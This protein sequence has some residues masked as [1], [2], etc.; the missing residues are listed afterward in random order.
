MEAD[1]AEMC[2]EQKG[3]VGNAKDWEASAVVLKRKFMC[4]VHCRGCVC[5]YFTQK[6]GERALHPGLHEDGCSAVI[7]PLREFL[8]TPLCPLH[9]KEPE[10]VSENKFG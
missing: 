10:S 6:N 3:E 7:S 8:N 5:S 1:E 9:A 4:A 2:V